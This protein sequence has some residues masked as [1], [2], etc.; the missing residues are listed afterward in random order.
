MPK[1][2]PAKGKRDRQSGLQRKHEIELAK[3]QAN[4]DLMRDIVR[5][6]GEDLRSQLLLVA[7]TG[8]G[9]SAVLKAFTDYKEDPERS[10]VEKET[11]FWIWLLASSGGVGGLV[12]A[13]LAFDK[14]VLTGGQTSP[15]GI[16][17]QMQAAAG[18]ISA[19]A[20]AALFASIF[21]GDAGLGGIIDKVGSGSGFGE[22]SSVAGAV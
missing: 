2:K 5:Y 18:N 12:L 8:A 9:V 17:S 16:V 7:L 21:M 11:P 10:E 1:G 20:W 19:M 4:N 14:Q 3:I 22:L 6:I 13:D 15:W